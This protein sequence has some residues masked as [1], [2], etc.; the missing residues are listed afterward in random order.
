M[1]NTLLGFVLILTRTS[2]FLLIIP[3]FSRQMLPLR[4]R[5]AVAI[6]LSLFLAMVHPVGPQVADQ[7][8]LEAVL[9][10][11]NEALYGLALGLVAMLI[12]S[13]IKLAARIIERE[14][15]LALAQ[16][17]DPMTGED[18]QP[19]STMM[20]MLFILLF[21][22]ADGHHLLLMILSRSYE[23]FPVGT[24]P[25]VTVLT[26]A[27][28]GAG[29]AMFMAALRLSAPILCAFLL[30]LVILA[31][32]ARLIPEMDIFFISMPLRAGMGLLL[33]SILLPFVH[34]FVTEFSDWM[35]KLLPI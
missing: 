16:T 9:L 19:L 4:I 17:L 3:V 10:I 27:V 26:E 34:G 6:L 15:G 25:T 11:A 22:C 33:M 23:A 2:A 32:F 35:A 21:L 20:E 18:T 5:L 24:I 13:V 31:V 8:W 29:S 7:T 28:V 12:F 30:L 1:L 14:M